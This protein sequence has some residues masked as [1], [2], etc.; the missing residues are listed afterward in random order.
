VSTSAGQ[1]SPSAKSVAFVN[2][3]IRVVLADGREI[4]APLAWF[5]RL[6]DAT[7]NERPNWRLV[8][9]GEGLHWPEV[10]EDIS[11][12]ARLGLPT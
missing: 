1:L 2:G 4:S 12:P 5:P 3:L 7:P 8:G 9:R 10:D 6:R 11:V